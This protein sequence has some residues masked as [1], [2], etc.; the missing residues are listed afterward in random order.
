MDTSATIFKFQ[1]LFILCALMAM[2]LINM[3]VL[4]DVDLKITSCAQ[5]AV[6]EQ[7]LKKGS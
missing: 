3:S 7:L 2:A 4:Y 6:S 5:V 1:V